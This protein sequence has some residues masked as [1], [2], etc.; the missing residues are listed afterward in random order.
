MLS[1]TAH[2]NGVKCLNTEHFSNLKTVVSVTMAT[3]L[4]VWELNIL[5]TLKQ[6]C[7]LPCQLGYMF[8]YWTFFMSKNGGNML[9]WKFKQYI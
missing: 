9:Y 6:C 4:N 3:G 8:E 5:A 1:V 2:G 7:L